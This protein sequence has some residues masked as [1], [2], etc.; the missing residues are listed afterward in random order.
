[1]ALT[2]FSAAS[3]L[4][5]IPSAV[6]VFAWLATLIAG[7]PVLKTP[8]LFILGFLFIFVVGGVTGVMFAA[9]PFDQQ[10]TDSYFVVAHFHYV[11]FGGAVF[12]IFAAIH[13]WVP[14]MYGRM[15]DEGLGKLAF[16][17]MFIGFNLTFFPMHIAGLLGMPRR[18]YTYH[19]GLGWDLWNMLS[20][21]G[22]VVLSL[23]ILVVIVNFLKSIRTGA[24]AGPDPWGGE[25][26]EWATSSPPP[27]YNFLEIP[28]VRSPEPVWDQPELRDLDHHVRAPES[29]LLG[30]QTMGTS[31]LDAEAESTLSM[32]HGSYVPVATALGMA[33]IFA[34]LLTGIVPVTVM[35]MGI[36]V[37]GVLFW[38]RV[39]HEEEPDARVV[40]AVTP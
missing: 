26:L 20:T 24:V 38:F 14:K 16:W 1:M 23:G 28:T 9:V 19:A 25:T 12:P 33:G 22:G 10:I 32:P 6:Q 2:F 39:R 13:Y 34:G 15:M 21:I 37:T 4:I 36:A 18:I 30:H 8:L 31:V 29:V 3:M 35:A 27:P 40:A 11:L 7:R 5:T 17:L